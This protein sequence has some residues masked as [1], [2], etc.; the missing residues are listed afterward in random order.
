[1]DKAI[2]RHIFLGDRFLTVFFSV[3][4][5]KNMAR[6]NLVNKMRDN[7]NYVYET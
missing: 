6:K 7:C 1:M 5:S 2:T 4:Q 3:F